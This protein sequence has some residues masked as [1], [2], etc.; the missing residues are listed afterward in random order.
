L[1]GLATEWTIEGDEKT[2]TLKLRDDVTFG[3]GKLMR[4]CE[5]GLDKNNTNDQLS[6]PTRS[7]DRVVGPTTL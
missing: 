2:I 7:I 1:P 6:G 4:R 3:S 5:E